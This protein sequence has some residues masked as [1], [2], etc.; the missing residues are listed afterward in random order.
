MSEWSFAEPL[1]IHLLWP[2]LFLLGFMWA[3]RRTQE[4][5]F[6][7]L[8][9]AAQKQKLVSRVPFRRRLRQLF[10]IALGSV[11]VVISLMRPQKMEEITI[12][13]LNHE[14]DIMVVLDV[15]KSMLAEDVAPNRLKRAKASIT[16]MVDQFVGYR[17]GLV[18]FAGRGAVL[19][20]LTKDYGYFHLS[21]DAASPMSISR[22]GTNI[23]DGLRKALDSFS[24]GQSARLLILIT[25]GEDHDSFP[26]EAAKQ[27]RALG[28]PIVAIG[29]GDENGSEIVITDP[30]T[31]ERTR[32]VDQRG[33]PVITR[34]D[35]ELLRE[36]ALETEGVFVPAGVA[37]LDL[38]SIISEHIQPI[39][40][41]VKKEEQSFVARELY[42]P[43]ILL[44]LV[45]FFLSIW[46]GTLREE[47]KL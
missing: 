5:K 35:G 8:F 22:G 28:V 45:A 38:T 20:P 27:A 1:A 12:S 39:V 13:R 41:E 3:K 42:P 18:G 23:G 26:M 30:K 24:D 29:F 15:S 17:V 47:G 6:Q 31:G 37:S 44:A 11:S 16:E 10:L 25:D 34:L 9:Q 7:A 46:T 21:L 14:A 32:V 43:F 36:I 33:K 40:S 19:C 4:L 2:L